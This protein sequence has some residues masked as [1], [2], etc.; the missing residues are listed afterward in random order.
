MKSLKEKKS[1]K[2]IKEIRKIFFFLCANSNMFVF[3][4]GESVVRS[5]HEI[6]QN[7]YEGDHIQI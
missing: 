7:R 2:D 3:H 5:T 1:L 6:G 4:R